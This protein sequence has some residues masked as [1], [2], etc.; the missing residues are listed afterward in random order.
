MNGPHLKRPKYFNFNPL[1]EVTFE[2][3]L[4]QNYYSRNLTAVIP[5]LFLISK[6]AP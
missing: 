4:P 2:N 1:S 3:N 5:S 6:S